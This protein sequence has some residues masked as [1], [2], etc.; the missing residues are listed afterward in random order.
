[1][2]LLV[3]LIIA[4]RRLATPP[5]TLLLIWLPVMLLPTILSDQPAH[6]LRAIGALPPALLLAAV[7]LQR[8]SE[9]LSGALPLRPSAGQALVLTA[10]LIVGGVSSYRTYFLD[11][12]YRSD[13]QAFF[14]VTDYTAGE[15]MLA[16]AQ[17][18]TL[19]LTERTFLNP[20]TNFVLESSSQLAPAAETP[21]H[22]LPVA[23]LYK[24]HTCRLSQEMRLLQRELNG[25]LTVYQIG[26][27]ELD[28]PAFL[29]AANGDGKVQDHNNQPSL[30]SLSRLPTIGS[31]SRNALPHVVGANIAK[32]ICLVAFDVTPVAATPGDEVMLTFYWEYLHESARGTVTGI[33]RLIDADGTE[34]YH[35]PLS[36]FPGSGTGE[37]ELFST[38]AA[39]NLPAE[40]H[41][42]KYLLQLDFATNEGEPLGHATV[43]GL[44]V[45]SGQK[46]SKELGN[47]LEIVAGDPPMFR[48][49]GYNITPMSGSP[50]S[51]QLMLKWQAL[52]PIDRDYTVFIHL[53][54]QGGDLLAQRDSEPM[55]GSAPTSW[56]LANEIIADPHILPLGSDLSAGNYELS[57]GLYYWQTG[58][59]LPLFD[60]AG[61]RLPDDVFTFIV[62]RG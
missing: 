28:V 26:A 4:L 46:G 53:R 61:Q 49:L 16:L 44:L 15:Q 50:T 8:V 59:R 13:T 22:D 10:V 21:R 23:L 31:L 38:S 14:D 24:P 1:V 17:S 34:I 29:A 55:D 37:G 60:G 51:L 48:L 41:P 36:G 18:T 19:L 39:F 57:L 27:H 45:D 56:W 33:A 58:E 32:E 6:P 9:W 40:M 3:G 11:W 12:A 20:T 7:G 54:D 25:A 43:G 30:F 2:G 35:F 52:R 47:P 5:Y 42:G 62:L